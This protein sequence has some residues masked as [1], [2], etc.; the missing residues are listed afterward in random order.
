[1]YR[2]GCHYLQVAPYALPLKKKK[3]SAPAKVTLFLIETINPRIGYRS[4][5][6]IASIA[7]KENEL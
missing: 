3:K 4:I 1:M 5:F 7:P 2:Y 6:I